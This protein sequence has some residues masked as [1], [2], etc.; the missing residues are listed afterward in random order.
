MSLVGKWRKV[1]TAEC[2]GAYPDEIEFLEARYLGKKGQSGQRFIIWD[3][4]VYHLTAADR[5]TIQTASDEL[6]PYRF[7][8]SGQTLKFVD[9]QGCEF[10]YVRAG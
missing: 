4:G 8:L 10:S 2:A 1:S 5:V 6:V 9:Q 7:S 3:A